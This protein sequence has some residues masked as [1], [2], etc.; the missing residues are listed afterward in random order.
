M[1]LTANLQPL[2]QKEMSRKEFM[3]TLGLGV[4]SIFGFSTIIHML[5]GKSVESRF[6]QRVS[7]GYSSSNYGQ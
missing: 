1:A 5:T 7:D 6:K 3:L 4:A 2:L